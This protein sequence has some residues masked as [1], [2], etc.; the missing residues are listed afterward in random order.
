MEHLKRIKI[1]EQVINLITRAMKNLR[2]ELVTEEQTAVE[3]KI[4]RSI[5]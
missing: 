5:F 4:Q 3:V 2:E 1:L